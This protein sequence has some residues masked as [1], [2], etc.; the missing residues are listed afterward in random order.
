MD[1]LLYGHR[2]R[3][4]KMFQLQHSNLRDSAKQGTVTSELVKATLKDWAEFSRYQQK[5]LLH[6]LSDLEWHVRT[7]LSAKDSSFRSIP[8][9][10]FIN[11]HCS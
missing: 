10:Y 3:R 8:H 11:A 7:S 6:F 1:Q 4:F 2:M 9:A 5:D